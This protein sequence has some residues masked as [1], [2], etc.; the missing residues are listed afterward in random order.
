MPT[1]LFIILALT[2]VWYALNVG[3]KPAQR[4]SIGTVV[5]IVVACIVVGYIFYPAFAP[6]VK[7]LMNAGTGLK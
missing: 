5:I 3:E 7:G 6:L 2:F 1:I 4:T